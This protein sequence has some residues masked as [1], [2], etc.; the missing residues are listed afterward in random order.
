M[1]EQLSR[2]AENATQILFTL[3]GDV[4]KY[5]A[6]IGSES[7]GSIFKLSASTLPD[8]DSEVRVPAYTTLL[9][10]GD[11]DSRLESCKKVVAVVGWGLENWDPDTESELKAESCQIGAASS[12]TRLVVFCGYN[13]VVSLL[14]CCVCSSSVKRGCCYN[15]QMGNIKH[16]TT[17]TT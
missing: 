5:S 16:A 11:V 4:S 1:V 6:C 12:V 13:S 3:S 17:V 7:S 8:A 2:R 14:A 9:H 15:K 10:W